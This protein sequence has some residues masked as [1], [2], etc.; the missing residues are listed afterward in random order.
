MVEV[1]MVIH[2]FEEEKFTIWDQDLYIN[3]W[4]ITMYGCRKGLVEQVKDH[5]ALK[6]H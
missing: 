1:T 3:A 4:A 2:V 6:L 5:Q